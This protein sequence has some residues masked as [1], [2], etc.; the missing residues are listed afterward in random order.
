MADR[1]L[2]GKFDRN[3]IFLETMIMKKKIFIEAIIA[4]TLLCLA[5]PLYAATPWLHTDGNKIKDP[6]GNTVVLRGVDLI[7]L[8]FLQD[9]Q[10]GAID[11]IDRLTNKSDPREVLPAGI[12]ESSGLMITP[13]DS[14]DPAAVGHIHSTRAIMISIYNLL[15]PVVD[16]CKT[17]DMYAIIDWHY[18]ANTY[19]HVASTSAFW[20]YMAPRFANDSHV[21]FELFNEPINDL[22]IW[23]RI[24]PT[25][26][27][28]EL[29]C[30]P[31]LILCALMR[32]IILSL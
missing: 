6:C 8:G 32:P 28:S 19:E 23:F 15:R 22:R 7:D 21:I 24:T 3:N 16:Y 29:I 26:K 1:T 25:G 4:C 9:W 31:G 30:R 12:R 2:A 5:T 27:A 14:V 18:V 11:M 10:G 13:P 20:T 17:K